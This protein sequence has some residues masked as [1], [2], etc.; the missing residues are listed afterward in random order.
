MARNF[1][2]SLLASLPLGFLWGIVKRDADLPGIANFALF[3][4]AIWSGCLVFILLEERRR[5]RLPERPRR[6]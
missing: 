2:I 1:A 4:L 6:R 5:T 3:A